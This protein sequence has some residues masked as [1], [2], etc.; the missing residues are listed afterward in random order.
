VVK[1]RDDV[2]Y[3][4]TRPSRHENANVETPIW[5]VSNDG[6]DGRPMNGPNDKINSWAYA[7]VKSTEWELKTHPSDQDEGG[8]GENRFDSIPST[9]IKKLKAGWLGGSGDYKRGQYASSSLL[10]ARKRLEESKAKREERTK[11]ISHPNF[12]M[13]DSDARRLVGLNDERGGESRDETEG[14][15]DES[16]RRLEAFR[17]LRQERVKDWRG[18]N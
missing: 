11:D 4:R 16:K 2:Y 6:G 18:G 12:D 7:P 3:S 14:R 5:F 15:L 17:K 8:L 9:E 10:S 1:S 13:S